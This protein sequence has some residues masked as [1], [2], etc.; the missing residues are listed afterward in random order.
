MI[1]IT[2]IRDAETSGELRTMQASHGG[3][4]TLCDEAAVGVH[5]HPTSIMFQAA[6]GQ[7]RGIHLETTER[8][9]RID[10]DRCQ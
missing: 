8:L 5:Q 7:S 10:M 4:F 9:D 6:I 3:Y 1:A 2:H